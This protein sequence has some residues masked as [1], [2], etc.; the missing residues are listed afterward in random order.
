[1]SGI[2][3]M[4]FI[5]LCIISIIFKRLYKIFYFCFSKFPV[6]YADLT[7]KAHKF[8][9]TFSVLL[10]ICTVATAV[11]AMNEYYGAVVSCDLSLHSEAY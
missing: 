2:E 4:N 3:L 7:E 10:P 8:Y 9:E 1:M 5:A 6:A 11:K